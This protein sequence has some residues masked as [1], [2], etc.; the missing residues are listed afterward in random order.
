MVQFG[1]LD[2][3]LWGNFLKHLKKRAWLLPGGIKYLTHF[4]LN[5]SPLAVCIWSH[6]NTFLNNKGKTV[7]LMCLYKNTKFCYVYSVLAA[8]LGIVEKED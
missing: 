2:S 1:Y 3:S 6:Y 7:V 5:F 8:Y 4:N